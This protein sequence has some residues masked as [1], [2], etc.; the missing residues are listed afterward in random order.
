MT[1]DGLVKLEKA[2]RVTNSGG[3]IKRCFEVSYEFIYLRVAGSGKSEIQGAVLM[4]S[5]AGAEEKNLVLNDRAAQRQ[6]VVVAM[7]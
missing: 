2:A 6:T 1:P 7:Q 4:N 3:I 5:L